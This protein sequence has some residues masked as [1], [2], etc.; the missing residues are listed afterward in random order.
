MNWDD[1]PDSETLNSDTRKPIGYRDS[2]Q[3]YPW[4]GGGTPGGGQSPPQKRGVCE[5]NILNSSKSRMLRR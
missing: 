4:P 1:K 5:K 2:I 3:K